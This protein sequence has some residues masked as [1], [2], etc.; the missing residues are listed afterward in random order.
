[1]TSSLYDRL[2]QS[3][4][5]IADATGQDSHDV[6]VVLGSGL[7]AYGDA[8]SD[9]TAVPYSEL[10][11]FVVPR[12]TGHAGTAYSL[13]RGD[14]RILLYA[15]RAHYYEG[16]DIDTV[17]LPIRAA[18]LHGCHT[19]VLS[20]AAGGCGDGLVPGDL[21]MISDH[22]NLAGASALRGP[23]DDRLGPRFPDMTDTYTPEL[24]S[25]ARRVGSTVDVDLKEGIY[26]WFQGPM[27]ETPAEVRMA[28][29][30]G[31]ALVG[32]STVPETTAARHMGA[33]VLAISLVTNLAAGISGHRLSAQ[34]VTEQGAASS[35]RFSR[36]IDALLPQIQPPQS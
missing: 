21:V 24:R 28:K 16:H 10:A 31:A 27:F 12:V 36:L 23:N 25:L 5:A 15:G 19:V 3:A 1:M 29:L 34:E 26:A 35:A 20:N 14:S 22:L 33:D 4:A 8:Q 6:V 11:G 32:M 30:A 2:E 18:L 13:Q 7:G 9:S 17:T